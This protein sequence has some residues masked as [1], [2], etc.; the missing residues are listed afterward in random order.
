MN[1]NYKVSN[2]RNTNDKQ[3]LFMYAFIVPYNIL[4]NAINIMVTYNLKNNIKVCEVV[5]SYKNNKCTYT[6]AFLKIF[7]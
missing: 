5:K 4:V 3:P 7:V 6:S 2:N 1:N